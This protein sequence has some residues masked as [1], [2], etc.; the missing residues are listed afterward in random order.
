MILNRY[1]LMA[2]IS[3]PMQALAGKATETFETQDGYTV[4]VERKGR[5]ITKL[6][7]ITG[8]KA[9][10]ITCSAF[11]D[12]TTALGPTPL[13]LYLATAGS[14]ARTDSQQGAVLPYEIAEALTETWMM[15]PRMCAIGITALQGQ[16]VVTV[17]NMAK[18]SGRSFTLTPDTAEAIG[19]FVKTT[20]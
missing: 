13:G 5:S 12:N 8:D 10:D 19:V 6:D 16:V 20:P 2:I 4:E 11:W 17:G 3:T 1:V 7:L 14:R 15:G 18:M 9:E